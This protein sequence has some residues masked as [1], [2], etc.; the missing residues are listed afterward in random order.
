M[1]SL[2]RSSPIH[3]SISS[4]K[5]TGGNI[6]VLRL[7]FSQIGSVWVPF[8][9]DSS[10]L[11]SP[12]FDKKFHPFAH[13]QRQLSP[14]KILHFLIIVPSHEIIFNNNSII[15][16]ICMLKTQIYHGAI[17]QTQNFLLKRDNLKGILKAFIEGER[18]K[19]NVSLE[20]G[21]TS[22]LNILMQTGSACP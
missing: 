15:I 2:G 21:T 3:S 14:F 4:W 20:C 18:K 17:R 11:L 7:S 9:S 19:T 16:N 1:E 10:L 13:M 6:T 22:T 12:G 5:E 8:F